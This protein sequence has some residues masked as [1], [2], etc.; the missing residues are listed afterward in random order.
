MQK[1]R[2][3]RRDYA[4]RH[5]VPADIFLLVEVADA[6]LDFDLS[7]KKSDYARSEIADYWVVDVK[8]EQ[9]YVFRQPV[10]GRYTEEN[11][12]GIDAVLLPLAFPNLEV[13]ISRF[14][15]PRE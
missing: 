9:V 13:A 14:F 10:A 7:E 3:D 6:T 11:V 1:L 2:N 12:L 5:P 15:P 4:D 8:A